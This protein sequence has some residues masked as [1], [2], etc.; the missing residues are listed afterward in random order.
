MGLRSST[1][2]RGRRCTADWPST[3]TLNPDPTSAMAVRPALL[4]I[5]LLLTPYATHAQGSPNWLAVPGWINPD[6]TAKRSDPIIGGVYY[7]TGYPVAAT[8]L[9]GGQMIGIDLALRGAF[10]YHDSRGVAH[11]RSLATSASGVALAVATSMIASHY[12]PWAARQGNARRY[13]EAEARAREL[14]ESIPRPL[15]GLAVGDTVFAR[16]AA[17]ATTPRYSVSARI[18]A[19]ELYFLP[20]G[21]VASPADS[22]QALRIVSI[23]RRAPSPAVAPIALG[24]LTGIGGA[25]A[26]CAKR[27][28]YC[29]PYST[30]WAAT[31]AGF[32]VGWLFPSTVSRTVPTSVAPRR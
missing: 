11:G 4:A 26:L 22:T 20:S 7:E 19:E 9:T 1:Y 5:A 8:I 15:A 32:G 30:M 23:R 10:R 31:T 29:Y 18:S 12:A 2:V 16:G 21:A 27:F 14:R 6:S 3:F 25:I 24:F 17:G 28:E 13:A